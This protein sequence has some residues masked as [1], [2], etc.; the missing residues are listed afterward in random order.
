M[1]TFKSEKAELKDWILQ[2][3]EEYI[4]QLKISAGNNEKGYDGELCYKR[5]HER[6]AV[7]QEYNRRLSALKKKYGIDTDSVGTITQESN[8]TKAK[9]VRV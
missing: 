3:N 4:E 5:E 1:K 8:L 7:V 2:K 6:K 9:K